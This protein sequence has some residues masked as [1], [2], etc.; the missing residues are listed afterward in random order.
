MCQSR[1]RRHYHLPP[2]ER[3]DLED[4][5]RLILTE[6][7]FVLHAPR[8]TGKT[9][10]LLALRDRLNGGGEFLCVY[11]NVEVGQA[12]REDTE[13]AMRAILGGLASQA[14]DIGD[15]FLEDAWPDVLARSGPDG[16]LGE[17]LARWCRASSRAPVVLLKVFHAGRRKS[18]EGTIAASLAQTARY[19]TRCGG[20]RGHLVV[21]DRTEGKSREDRVLRREE[22]VD[23]RTIIVRG[24]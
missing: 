23:G 15:S 18:L 2:L 19:L 3:V 1:P 22:R 12:A 20:G 21:F 13:R 4:M 10:A 6:R 24:M 8:Q 16:A 14:V 9:S 11:V 7:Y 17:A 5:L